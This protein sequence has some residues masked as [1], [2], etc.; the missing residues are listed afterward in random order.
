MNKLLID[1]KNKLIAK[2]KDER[3]LEVVFFDSF[4]GNIYR[5]KVVNKIDS[6][7]SYFVEVDKNTNFFL[8]S[9]LNYKIGDNAIV[10]CVREAANNKLALASENFRIENSNY[11]VNRYPLS[12]RPK[13]LAG[14]NKNKKLYEELFYLKQKLLREEN[15]Y[16]SP[17][18]LYKNSVKEAY[19]LKNKD[20]AVENVDI[21][22]TEIFKKV[23][24]LIASKKLIYKDMSI[25]IDE[26]ETLTV[27][28]VN[29]E[30]RKSKMKKEDFLLRVNLDIIDY[31]FYNLKLRNIGG[32]VIIDFLRSENK[33]KIIGEVEKAIE[34]YELEAEI[35]GF[36][37]MGLFE[38]TIK[39]RGENLKKA[40]KQR[41]LF[42]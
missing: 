37:E 34:N 15:F 26:L 19:I 22:K 32:M 5:A 36:S 31:I 18:L 7:K 29:T 2:I 12:Q 11:F 8:K 28:D 20:L 42:V 16:P 14:K 17:K 38:L 41:G 13:L 25:I 1:D 40:L 33:E 35:F 10:Q 39:R 3:V 21:E 4:I 27:V 24:N 9:S 30:N 6:L 23:L